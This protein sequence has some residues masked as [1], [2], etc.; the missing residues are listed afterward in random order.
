MGN[1]MAEVKVNNSWYIYSGCS[2]HMTNERLLINLQRNVSSK[3]KMGIRE[4][5]N[6]AGKG[7]P[8]IE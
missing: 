2:N 7:T 3:V 4:I 8:V 1:A 6:V 5:V